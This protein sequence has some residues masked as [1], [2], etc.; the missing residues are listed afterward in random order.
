[1]PPRKL[2]VAF[3]NRSLNRTVVVPQKKPEK[4][5][6]LG[7]SDQFDGELPVQKGGGRPPFAGGAGVR[8][9]A[10]NLQHNEDVARKKENAVPRRSKNRIDHANEETLLQQ[11]L[12]FKGDGKRPDQAARRPDAEPQAA[13]GLNG[14]DKL[15]V[16]GPV[17]RRNGLWRPR[18]RSTS[19]ESSASSSTVDL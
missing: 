8:R 1:V 9:S 4:F 2:R 16:I 3:G 11:P 17:G 13:G 10:S 12:D 14:A 19:D 6:L 18:P 7:V 15:G 5:V